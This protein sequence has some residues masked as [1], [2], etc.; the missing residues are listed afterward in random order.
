MFSTIMHNLK[1]ILRRQVADKDNGETIFEEKLRLFRE[2]FMQWKP[3]S[4]NY[5]AISGKGAVLI[6]P[7]L[8][9]D[10]PYFSLALGTFLTAEGKEITF[11][12]DDSPFGN[13]L[14]SFS[15]ELRAINQAL[16]L[17]SGSCRVMKIS[18]DNTSSEVAGFGSSIKRLSYLNAI[19]FMRG[20]QKMEG[21]PAYQSL[22]ERQLMVT[23]EKISALLLEN[24]YDFLLVPGGIYGTTGLWCGI[25]KER[26]IR[27][28]TYDSGPG[29]LLIAADGIAAQLSDL[30]RAFRVLRA[31]PEAREFI[32]AS[33]RDEMSKRKA[34]KDKFNSQLSASCSAT[35]KIDG[36]VL[37]AL[38]SSWDSAALGL[39]DIFADGAQWIIET[40]RWCLNYTEEMIIVRQ[41]PAER[42]DIART[43]DDYRK[44][45]Q[46]NFGENDRVKFVAAED[47]IN[48]YEILKSVKVVAVHTTTFGVEAA[49][50]GK[51]VIT[52][53]KPYYSDLGFVWKC[54]TKDQY[55]DVLSKALQGDILVKED[56]MEAAWYCY[57]LSQCCNW[58]LSD[59]TPVS[60]QEWGK[61]DPN[62]LYDEDIVKLLLK[63]IGENIPI[64][65]LQHQ[66]RFESA[67]A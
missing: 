45:L 5:P 42:K 28:A 47:D 64:S 51:I 33:A 20:E 22:I 56:Q 25:A 35:V 11:I 18:D 27:V 1:S 10:V 57:Y 55:F 7:W 61:K 23:A 59:F 13:D 44:L 46:D 37:I 39:Y 38:N 21:R 50:L 48:T 16:Q 52:G 15:S 58:I 36:S 30:P 17:A 14:V 62:K 67:T 63:S 6:L 9:T 54:T 34:G 29:T 32:L 26:G 53:S 49:A 8:G 40:V 43:T 3:A 4:T 31:Q 65:L 60:L 2:F 24:S 19:W 66:Q 12:L 41:H